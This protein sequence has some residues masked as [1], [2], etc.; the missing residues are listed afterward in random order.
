MA[1]DCA[2]AEELTRRLLALEEG[3]M[4]A[5]A[6][7]RALA[8]LE[9]ERAAETIAALVARGGSGESSAAVAAVAQALLD[10]GGGLDYGW[11]A[12]LYAAAVEKGLEQVTSLLLSP[13]PRRAFEEP[14]DKPDPRLAHLSLGHK[15]SMARLHRDPDLLARLAAEGEPV[16]VRELLRNALLTEPFAVRI[17][18]RRP[19]RPATLRCLYQERRWRTRP[20]VLLALVRNPFLETEIALKILPG[21][22]SRELAEI[23][24]DGS[25]HALVRAMAKRLLEDRE[26]RA[27][28]GGGGGRGF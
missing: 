16:V 13:P 3:P 24:A 19:C 12:D 21:V 17:A 8:A 9:P 5:R 7:G 18:A 25:L 20:A 14:F 28:R 4:R 22:A 6:A 10:S 27:P 1:W 2:E 11:L 23:A 15:K 26:G